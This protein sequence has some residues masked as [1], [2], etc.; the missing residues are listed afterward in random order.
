MKAEKLPVRYGL[1]TLSERMTHAQALAYG[2]KHFLASDLKKAGFKVSIF[3]SDPVI[4][5]SDFF[6]INIGKTVHL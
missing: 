6:R 4:N 5:G 2:N 1:D 3:R